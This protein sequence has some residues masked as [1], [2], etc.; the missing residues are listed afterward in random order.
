MYGVQGWRLRGLRKSEDVPG[1]GDIPLSVPGVR[2][3]RAGRRGR[4]RGA[5]GQRRIILIDKFN[6]LPHTWDTG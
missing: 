2:R 3:G 4:V 1:P 5:R 6:F